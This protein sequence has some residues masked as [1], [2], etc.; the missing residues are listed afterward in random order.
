MAESS[1]SGSPPDCWTGDLF[2]PVG[3][4]IFAWVG[5]ELISGLKRLITLGHGTLSAYTE[6]PSNL[7]VRGKMV[8][9]HRAEALE[10]GDDPIGSFFFG[11]VFDLD[12][13]GVIYACEVM[14]FSAG[15]SKKVG[16]QRI[17]TVDDLRRFHQGEIV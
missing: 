6:P 4:R 15:A 14:W 8:C 16:A 7:Y 10:S 17:V 2:T 12:Q 11:P 1:R 13:G 3:S 9:V 5:Y